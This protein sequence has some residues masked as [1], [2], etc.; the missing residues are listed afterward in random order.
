MATIRTSQEGLQKGIGGGIM[1]Y[2]GTC[3]HFNIDK[4]PSTHQK[5]GWFRR[6]DRKDAV[7]MVHYK[8]ENDCERHEE[9]DN[10]NDRRNQIKRVL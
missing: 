3:K 5:I 8:S 10:I 9:V 6:D 1:T 2:C 7:M 4:T